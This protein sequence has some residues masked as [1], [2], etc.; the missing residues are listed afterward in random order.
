MDE[1]PQH[2]ATSQSDI[3]KGAN[4]LS[5]SYGVETIYLVLLSGRQ[6]YCVWMSD[7]LMWVKRV[8]YVFNK[9]RHH[10]GY[11]FSP[12]CSPVSLIHL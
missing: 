6:W 5:D 4:K 11:V 2:I 3:D 12:F 1:K 8:E 7:N 9:A 10:L